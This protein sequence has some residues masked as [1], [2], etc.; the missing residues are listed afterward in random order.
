MNEQEKLKS[1]IDDLCE[2]H[3]CSNKIRKIH[4]DQYVFRQWNPH[5]PSRFVTW[6]QSEG[7]VFTEKKTARGWFG[8][9][10]ETAFNCEAVKE[11]YH[12]AKSIGLA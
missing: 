1:E 10:T 2:H 3:G 6:W 4:F 5:P 8:I 11:S 12:E 9:N 7:P